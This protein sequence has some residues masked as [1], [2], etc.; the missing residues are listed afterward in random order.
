MEPSTS[1]APR[2]WTSLTAA[3]L[4]MAAWPFGPIPSIGR[5]GR[6]RTGR[7]KRT[8]GTRSTGT[9]VEAIRRRFSAFEATSARP[10]AATNRLPIFNTNLE[11][12]GGAEL[13]RVDDEKRVARSVTN[14]VDVVGDHRE[15]LVVQLGDGTVRASLNA[16]EQPL[17]VKP[18]KL[19]DPHSRRFLAHAAFPSHVAAL[20]STGTT[21]TRTTPSRPSAS[22]T[23]TSRPSAPSSGGRPSPTL[24]ERSA[25]RPSPSSA[26]CSSRAP[27]STSAATSPTSLLR[28]P[29]SA[30]PSSLSSRAAAASASA[31][32]SAPRP[33]SA[34]SSR[35]RTSP[36]PCSALR[37]I[38]PRGGASEPLISS[39]ALLII[40]LLLP[41]AH[42]LLLRAISC[43]LQRRILPSF[44]ISFPRSARA[45][46]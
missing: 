24:R 45:L 44:E 2:S 14:A 13:F 28:M 25:P 20:G 40:F 9:A 37:G 33:R 6:S 32:A 27:A 4:S 18:T 15:D 16:R 31:S 29:R 26:N 30:S 11:S 1:R 36:S 17:S 12:S 3:A 42:P 5:P 21:S 22:S 8:L 19:E 7:A 35:K 23:P 43:T 34:S 39:R 41:A 38:G 10:A 46:L